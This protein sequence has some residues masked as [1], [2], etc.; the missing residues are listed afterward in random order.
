MRMLDMGCGYSKE[1]GSI[2]IDMLAGSDADVFRWMA[3]FS[4]NNPLVYEHRLAFI[5]PLLDISSYLKV[6]KKV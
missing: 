6:D 1:K 5:F 4:T 2:G 3:N